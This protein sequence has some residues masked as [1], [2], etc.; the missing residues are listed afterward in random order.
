MVLYHAVSSYQLL[1]V[2]LHRMAFHGNDKAV[3]ILPDF[4]TGK[5]PQYKKLARFFDEVYLFPYLQIPHGDERQIVQDVIRQYHRIIPYGIQEF[6]EIYIAGAHFYFTLYL[7]EK[8][9]SFAFFEDAAGMLSRP[10][11]LAL[12]LSKNFPVHAAIAQKH[13][14]FNGKN[15]YIRRVICLR[16]AQ[17]VDSPEERWEDFSV[18]EQLRRLSNGKRKAIIRF[19]LKRAIGTKAEAILLTQHFANLGM[20]SEAE[21]KRLYERLRDGPLQ[22]IPMVIK[23]HPDDT[24]DYGEIFPGAE[25]IRKPFPSELLAYVFRQKPEVIY[26]F[27]STGCENLRE[28]FIIRRIGRSQYMI[29]DRALIIVNSVYQLLTAVHMK[30]SILDGRAVDL[31]VTD[32]TPKMEAYVPRL[33]ETGMFDRVIFGKTQELNKKVSAGSDREI[34]EEFQNAAAIFRWRLS[35]ELS[36]YSEVYFSNY[37]IF[38]RML[39]YHFAQQNCEFI[40][41]EDGFSTYVI[42]FLREDRAAINRHAEG[43]RIREKVNKVLLYEPRLA[44]RG[45]GLANRALP[46]IRRDDRELRELLNYIFEYEKPDEGAEFIF[47]EQSFRAEGL[48]TNDIELMRECQQ[49]VGAGR[50]VVKPHPRN[51]E[52]LPFQLGLT[53]RYPSAAP[54]ELFLLNENPE[55]RTIITVC[56]NAALTSRIVF[57]LDMNTVMLYRLFQ[58]KV[59]WKEDQVL[60]RYLHKFRK[61]FA[62]SKY[63]VPDTVYEL[64]NILRF[65]GGCNE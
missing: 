32:V 33:R 49:T 34:S 35:D 48:K 30:R 28:S 65:L 59:L 17:T 56:S 10:E 37:D 15:P 45:D 1:E 41:F 60:E 13:G 21:Q 8:G 14:L 63:Y 57:G 5:Y 4:I 40:C 19:F 47:L 9:I 29:Y 20:M 16:R 62:G 51:P 3:L 11:E 36:A 61:Q 50:F 24:I 39:A 23:P 38:T 31:I 44:M 42:D 27:D 25:I 22:G 6:E 52:N 53:R 18:E 58:G 64:R 26:T 43:K 2:I 12:A 7:L 46:K 54:W 55:G